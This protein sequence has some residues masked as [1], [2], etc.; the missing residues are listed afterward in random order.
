[1]EGVRIQSQA[2]RSRSPAPVHRAL[3]TTDRL[4]NL[5][6]RHGLA[7]GLSL[8]AAFCLETFAQRPRNTLAAGE[9]SLSRRAAA[10]HPGATVSLPV[11]AAWRANVVETQTDRRMVASAFD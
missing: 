2:R 4:A 11:C 10:L 6:R 1:M 3:P 9:Q 7:G 8:D 5:V